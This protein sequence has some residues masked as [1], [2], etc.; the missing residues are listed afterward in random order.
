MIR[1]IGRRRWAVYS[2]DVESHNDDE[3]IAKKE[4]SVWLYSF[5]DET[6]KPEDPGSF[7]YSVDE[8]IDRVE[9]L[10][11][12]KRKN[13]IRPCQNLRI[14]I[15][16]ASFEWSFLLPVLLRRGYQWKAVIED[17]DEKVF[18]STTTKSC[19][20]VWSAT[21]KPSRKSGQIVFVDLC[22]IFPGSLRSI[23][24]SFHLPTQKGDIDYKLN[25]L[26][27][28]KVTDEERLYCFKDTKIVM[29]ILSI[30]DKKDDKDFFKSMSAAGYSARQLMR[31]GFPHAFKPLKAF[32]KFY[33]R[34][35]KDE[36]DYLRNGVSGGISYA[37]ENWQFKDIRQ[38]LIHIDAHQ[39]HPS[40]TQNHLFP[41]GEGTFFKG[42]PPVF[43]ISLCR[44]L[45]SYTGVKIHSVIKLIG[46]SMATDVELYLW[47]FEIPTALKCYENATV[48]YLDGYSY[49]AKPLPW[50]KFYSD[51]YDQRLIAK[52]S[53]DDFNIMYYKMLNN[54]GGYGKFVEH[55][56]ETAFRN[57]I[58]DAGVIDSV[59]EQK[60]NPDINA[61]YTYI[62]AGACIPAYSRVCL[63]ETALKLGWRNV[64]YFDTDS[65]FAVKNAEVME[66]LSHLDFE[67]HLGGW[68]REPDILK[69]Q[70]AAPKRYK[71]VEEKDGKEELTV[72]MAGVN[73]KNDNDGLMRYDP[74]ESSLGSLIPV[75]YSLNITSEKY[76][77]QGS[78]KAKGGTL[79]VFKPKEIA[80]QPKY[81]RAFEKNAI[82]KP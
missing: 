61:T 28:H 25:R 39:M 57:V 23:A 67:D 38:R 73:F 70:F 29:D 2:F 26:H 77:V 63:C 74:D 60:E 69:A 59:V 43:R 21:L 49:R 71:L 51:N 3:S 9:A 45:F 64:V 47:S 30:M 65:I 33:P 10:S 54:A 5:I 20:S 15:W 14:Y 72:H 58:N 68:G 35:E 48:K 46:V 16:N 62:P 37:S 66:G 42:V 55:G 1:R 19:S 82:M 31:T 78:M 40:Q 44:V 36:S 27:G 12:P 4:T 41:C 8:F 50:K 53:K 24:K 76:L 17:G 81:L 22:K 79:I 18:N 75:D 34:L 13:N 7:G 6:S 32:R 11:S 56:H 80:V 52:K